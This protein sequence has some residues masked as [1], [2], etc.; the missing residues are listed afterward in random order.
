MHRP[1]DAAYH[2]PAAERAIRILRFL[3]TRRSAGVSEI[4][5]AL[6][7]PVGNCFALL[8]TL[9]RNGFATFDEETK[10]Y[11]LGFAV[12][13]L[14]GAMLQNMDIIAMARPSLRQ[15]LEATHQSS[16]VAQRISETRLMIID[17][18]ELR[19]EIRLSIPIGLRFPVTVGAAG[20]CLLA[21]L[22]AREAEHLI[23][24][25]GLHARTAKAIVNV[26]KYRRALQKA[27]ADGYARSDEEHLP[28]ANAISA[29]V[30]DV[31][32]R[33]SLVLVSVGISAA[34]PAKSLA[35]NGKTLRGIADELT[36]LTGGRQ[37]A[38]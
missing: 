3:K 7:I 35:R 9:Q 34:A 31:H 14:A 26:E 8:K 17:K 22:D 2:V 15:A 13:E 23:E 20:R 28:G 27:R 33:P 24:T 30:F 29:P 5:K 36:A 37:P 12:L 16:Y 25:V 38:T 11:G 18:E 6:E 10:K 32:G 21:Y 1:K 4:A 19:N